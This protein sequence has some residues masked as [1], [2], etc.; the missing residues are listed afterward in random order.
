MAAVLFVGLR[1][2]GRDGVRAR[3][4]AA[5]R[6]S[7]RGQGGLHLGSDRAALPGYAGVAGRAVAQAADWAGWRCAVG[8]AVI[9]LLLG[10][11]LQFVFEAAQF[12]GQIVGMQMGFSLVNILDPQT[13]VDTP[14]LSDLPPT[15]RDC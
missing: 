7:V 15:D 5:T 2:A 12:A 6:I 1:I 4:S 11:T 14:V 9:G 8:E 13:Q 3:F 10:L